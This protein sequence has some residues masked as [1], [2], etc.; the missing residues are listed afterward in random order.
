MCEIPAEGVQDFLEWSLLIQSNMIAL[1][2]RSFRAL[3]VGTEARYSVIHKKEK[4]RK[5]FFL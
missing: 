2:K 5:L 3:L 4:E 1:A